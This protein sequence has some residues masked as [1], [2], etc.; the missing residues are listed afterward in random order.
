MAPTYCLCRT[1]QHRSQDELE[2]FSL[3][4]L[5]WR[6]LGDFGIAEAH[7]SKLVNVAH[8]RC[9][10]IVYESASMESFAGFRLVLVIWWYRTDFWLG[11]E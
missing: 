11:V 6:F 2:F 5:D 8:A 1:G 4:S 7:Q 10:V 9:L 3:S